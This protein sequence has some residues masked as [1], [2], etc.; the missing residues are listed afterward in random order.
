MAR[1]SRLLQAREAELAAQVA[2]LNEQMV[3]LGQE[4]RRWQQ[5]SAG[6][7][8]VTL[9]L[10]MGVAHVALDTLADTSKLVGYS[11]L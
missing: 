9:L 4:L 8:L 2:Q 7:L 11:A 5:L 3:A 10:T 1:L 6:L